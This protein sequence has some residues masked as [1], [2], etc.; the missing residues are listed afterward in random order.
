MTASPGASPPSGVGLPTPLDIGGLR[1]LGVLAYAT[2]AGIFIIDIS[3]PLGVAGGVPYVIPMLFA[4]RAPKDSSIYLLAGTCSVLTVLGFFL[5]TPGGMMWMVVLNRALALAA[6]WAPAAAAIIYKRCDWALAEMKNGLRKSRE[7]LALAQQV[8]L[9]GSWE[10]DL[11]TDEANVSDGMYKLLGVSPESFQPSLEAFIGLVHP[12]DRDS[13]RKAI[14]EPLASGGPFK[15][16]FRLGEGDDSLKHILSRGMVFTDSGGEPVRMIGTMLDI[17]ERKRAEERLQLASKV[18]QNSIEGIMVTDPDSVI[19]VV[20]PGF[21]QITGYTTEEAIGRTPRLLRSD[22]HDEAFYKRLWDSILKDGRWEGE[23]WNRR[24]SGEAYPEWLTISTIKDS[25]GKTINYIAQ[26]H[27]ITEIKR[28]E[29]EIKYRAWHDAL[30]GLP[31]RELFRDRVDVA[32]ARAIRSGRK[33]AVFFID[34]DNFKNINDSLGHATGD[35]FLQGVAAR[36]VA[37]MREE[38]TISRFGGDEFTILIEDME[39]EEDVDS[40]ARKIFQEM[41][42]PFLLGGQELFVTVSVGV[43][44]YPDDGEEADTII[45]NADVAMYRAKE[46]GKNNYMLYTPAMNIRMFERLELESALRKAIEREEFTLYYQPKVRLADERIVGAEALIRWMRQEYGVV[47]PDK[48]IPLAEETGLILQIGKWVIPT[49]CAQAG[50]WREAG[51]E[52]VSVAVNISARRFQ[53]KGLDEIV[54]AALKKTGLPPENL[55][56]EITESVVMSDVQV[57]IETLRTVSVMGVRLA[58]DDFGTGYS[59]LGYLKKFPID[60]LK[61]DKSFVQDITEEPDDAAIVATIISM[62]KNMGLKVVAE[63]V[64]TAEQLA[65][66]KERGCDEA[67]G[68]YFSRPVPAGEFLELLRKN[69]SR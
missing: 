65:F 50:E 47:P 58:V 25:E 44:I 37:L 22:R 59:S 66:L 6:I 3:L 57:A 40:V 64:E 67:Q 42:E 18:F 20:N 21:T 7:A 1:W 29:E 62:A 51:Y 69:R 48:F 15:V 9:L 13:V 54:E 31:N 34:L 63:G 8:A 17:T 41:A 26:F 46:R 33:A 2:A 23:I 43:A 68:Y 56:L 60:S 61:I 5:S 38:D 39:H 24:K 27:D 4:F 30:T 36:L 28:H 11:K 55:E 14:N 19:R 32:I 45:K 35:L 53:Q 16:E 49:A 52:D 10:W 12:E